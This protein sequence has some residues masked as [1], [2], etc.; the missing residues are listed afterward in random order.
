MSQKWLTLVQ[1]AFLLRMVLTL[2][3]IRTVLEQMV[4]MSIASITL[5][6]LAT[7]ITDFIVDYQRNV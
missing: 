5:S 1:V 7:A 3:V 4:K 2:I 6:K